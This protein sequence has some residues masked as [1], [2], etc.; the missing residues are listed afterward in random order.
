MPPAGAI[1]YPNIIY[2]QDENERFG[3]RGK[4][5]INTVLY[6]KWLKTLHNFA[7]INIA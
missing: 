1:I 5:E 6:R 2:D 4:E 7:T 3:S